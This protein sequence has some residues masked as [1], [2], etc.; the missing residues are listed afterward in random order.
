MP[1]ESLSYSGYGHH[2]RNYKSEQ[3]LK[4]SNEATCYGQKMNSTAKVLELK[5]EYKGQNKVT[6]LDEIF[7]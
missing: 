1:V 7:L 6:L 2:W 4:M 5:E 3:E